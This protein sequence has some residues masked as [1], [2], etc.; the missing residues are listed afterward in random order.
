MYLGE[1]Y[2]HVLD[3]TVIFVKPCMSL[4]CCRAIVLKWLGVTD[5]FVNLVKYGEH[6]AP[7]YKNV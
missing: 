7:F 4:Q 6:G 5:S 2:L 3:V 1:L